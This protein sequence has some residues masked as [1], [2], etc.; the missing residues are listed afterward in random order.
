MCVSCGAKESL[1]WRVQGLPGGLDVSAR[2]G[3]PGIALELTPDGQVVVAAREASAGFVLAPVGPPSDGRWCPACA[4]NRVPETW[5]L[6][7][8]LL[9]FSPTK[10]Y[11]PFFCIIKVPR[12]A[13]FSAP[14]FRSST[15]PASRRAKAPRAEASQET[16]PAA[17]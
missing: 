15:A 17:Y 1:S 10:N 13:H 8:F 11:I 4:A 12:W 5:G 6:F 3:E 7:G 14:W 9:I 16:T 2:L